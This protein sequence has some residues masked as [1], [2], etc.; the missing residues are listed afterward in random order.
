MVTILL[1]FVNI[2]WWQLLQT[3]LKSLKYTILSILSNVPENGVCIVFILF[4]EDK[5]CFRAFITKQNFQCLVKLP[6]VVQ[7][8][9]E[10][11]VSPF[12]FSQAHSQGLMLSIPF[13]L[14]SGNFLL[15]RT[16]QL[17]QS[18]GGSLRR[19]GAPGVP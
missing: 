11:E 18:Q 1:C 19:A 12:P 7:V 2:C 5:S 3:S 14:F 10:G 4:K 6:Y 15:C 17:P 9:I 13:S 16:L 8:I